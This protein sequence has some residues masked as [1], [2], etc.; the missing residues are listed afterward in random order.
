[1]QLPDRV[2]EYDDA[3]ID[4][5]LE[6]WYQA[7]LVA[8]PFLDEEFLASERR[9]IAEQFLPAAEVTVAI[10]DGQVVGFL[11][12]VDHEVGG[13]FVHPDHQGSGLGRA[14]MDDARS[15]RTFLEVEVFDAN[16]IGR[17]FYA[18]YGFREIGRITDQATGY[19]ARRLRIDEG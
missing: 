6:C 5:V 17:R 12:L 16:S 7:S 13:I 8:H 19:P 15:R 2:R 4:R 14:L 1:M 11:S 3:D 18:A 10:A 9:L